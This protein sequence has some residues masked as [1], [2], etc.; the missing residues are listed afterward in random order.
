MKAEYVEKQ[1]EY[2]EKKA[3]AKAL[4]LRLTCTICGAKPRT[5]LK[6]PCGTTQYCSTDCQRIDW[7]ERG[8]RKACKKIRK[9]AAEAPTPPPSPP[10]DVFYGPAPRSRADEVRARIAAEH[11]AARALREANPEQ[12]PTSARFG[13]RCP[14]CLEEWDVN[15]TR[16]FRVCCCR[17]VCQSCEDKI[18]NACP[19]CR[20]P[21]AETNAELLA[22]L[23]RHV[24]NEVPEAIAHL[25]N[26]YSR[27]YYDLVKS[28]KKAAKIYRRAVELGDVQAI[29]N[30]GTL[31]V[32]GSGVKLDKKKAEELFRMAAD[33]GDAFAQCNLGFLLDSEQRFEEAFRYYALAAD[34]GDTGAECN[35]GCC[36]RDGDG[37]EQ[38]AKKAAKLFRRAVE[39]GNLRAMC[40]L[41]LLYVHGE[42][43]KQS[44][45]KANQLYR[46]AA[47]RGSALGQCNLGSRYALEGKFVDAARYYKLSAEQGYSK[48]EF[49]LAQCYHHGD[50]VER[51]LE[52]AKR[53][54]ARA[55]A[56]GD[57][58]AMY[59]LGL[60]CVD[61][62]GEV[63]QNTAEHMREA[64]RWLESAV[65]AGHETAGKV[66]S[67]LQA[68]LQRFESSQCPGPSEPSNAPA[69]AAA[70]PSESQ[71]VAA[72]T[73][74]S[75]AKAAAAKA[76][77]AKAWALTAPS[78]RKQ[79]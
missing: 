29:V 1:R 75:K 23:R 41:A 10:R 79:K 55:S 46:I 54:F 33:R 17:T 8:H 66:L 44:N 22:R 36:Y 34:Q 52:I 72:A 49:N 57:S 73:A 56:K 74:E 58:D 63:T 53:W 15:A 24:E 30:L 14:I 67:D 11:E 25:A 19:L 31:Y 32:T 38:S 71:A 16:V 64:I 60:C 51:D 40:A 59:S 68:W 47:D 4:Q 62:S 35:L 21:R 20:L 77:V 70:T 5:L 12:E 76:A 39:R 78:R 50:G 26:A 18:G 2:E 37:T 48:A 65:A 43:V 45:Q 69:A 13:S 61:L 6:C 27:G 9:R 7:R 3:R 42:G 28:D